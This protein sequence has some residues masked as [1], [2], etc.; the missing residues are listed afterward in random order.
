MY[1]IMQ[2]SM[3]GRATVYSVCMIECMIELD[4]TECVVLF[5]GL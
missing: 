2:Y 1:L 5:E 4:F 3:K